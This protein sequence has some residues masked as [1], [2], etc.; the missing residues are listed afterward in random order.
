MAGFEQE[1]RSRRVLAEPGREDSASGAT[2][3]DD[4][5]GGLGEV[6]GSVVRSHW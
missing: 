6:R 1:Y 2:A 3:D 5:I 4:H